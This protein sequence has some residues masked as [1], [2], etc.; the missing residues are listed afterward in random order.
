MY[1]E[2]KVC[3]EVILVSDAQTFS[4][5]CSFISYVFTQ[6]QYPYRHRECVS[7]VLRL[8]DRSVSS[9]SDPVMVGPRS[10]L[11]HSAHPPFTLC[12]YMPLAT[13]SNT[14]APVLVSERE[15]GCHCGVC[16]KAVS[17]ILIS[18]AWHIG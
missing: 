10:A 6:D 13:A 11:L 12:P 2:K 4:D 8:F 7:C 5:G 18:L 1:T 15:A 3:L 16:W 14:S 9:S 17:Q